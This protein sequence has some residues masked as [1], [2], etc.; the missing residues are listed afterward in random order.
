MLTDFS[1]DQSSLELKAHTALAMQTAVTEGDVLQMGLVGLMLSS[2]YGCPADKQQGEAWIA[3]AVR[4]GAE[5]PPKVA[6]HLPTPAAL[7]GVESKSY[8]GGG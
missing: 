5:A 1:H 6:L 3:E 2:G 4:R 7:V 8:T